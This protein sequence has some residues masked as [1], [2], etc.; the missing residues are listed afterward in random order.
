MAQEL[1]LQ[2]VEATGGAQ[3]LQRAMQR[4]DA[5]EEECASK[6]QG[7]GDSD[8]ERDEEEEE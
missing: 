6:L 5:F 2:E 3:A 7:G 4:L 8:S 1:L